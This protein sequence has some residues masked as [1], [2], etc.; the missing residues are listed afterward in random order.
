M[1]YLDAARPLLRL[2]PEYLRNNLCFEVLDAEG[3]LVAFFAIVQIAARTMLDHLWVEPSLI[4]KG[5]GRIACEHVFALARQQGWKELRILPEPHAERF[6][7][8]A[9]FS[10]TGERVPSRVPGGPVFSVYRIELRD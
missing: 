1:A 6:Y 2:A 5:I 10:D 9:G 3:G 4:G 7:L 8:K